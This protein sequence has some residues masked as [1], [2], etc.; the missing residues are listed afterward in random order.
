MTR[1]VCRV[2]SAVVEKTK[3][4]FEIFRLELDGELNATQ[5]VPLKDSER[6]SN[7]LYQISKVSD[8]NL[9]SLIGKYVSLRLEKT[10]YGVQFSNV[11]SCD[12]LQDFKRLLD[13]ANGKAFNTLLDVYTLLSLNG[14]PVNSDKSIT[15]R[16]LYGGLDIMLRDGCVLC[17]PN[18]L[19]ETHLTL[20]DI[21][22]IYNNFYKDREIDTMND[23]RCS[24]Y[25]LHAVAIVE[26]RS[27]YH[28]SNGKRL[29]HDILDVL[30]IGDKLSKEQL[31]Y[32]NN[33]V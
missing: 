13:T 5:L 4:G 30:R 27:I 23:D 8:F 12:V 24:E 26:S 25:S 20:G 31:D 9:D 14:Y 3:R 32:I 2:T 33:R 28:K 21:E 22:S 16:G 29:S 17:Y 11:I 10:Q 19:D 18:D 7:K 15:L 1:K 6:I